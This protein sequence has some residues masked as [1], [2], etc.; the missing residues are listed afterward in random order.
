MGLS[1]LKLNKKLIQSKIQLQ[2][3]LDY[4]FNIYITIKIVFKELFD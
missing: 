1:S 4:I 2:L 3:K